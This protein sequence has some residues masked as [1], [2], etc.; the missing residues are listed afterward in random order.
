MTDLSEIYKD[1]MESKVE[2]GQDFWDEQNK[3]L[4]KKQ[5]E[6]AKKSRI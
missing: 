2:L 6:F 3:R 1:F 5:L 4:R